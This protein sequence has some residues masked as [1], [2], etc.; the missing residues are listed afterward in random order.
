MYVEFATVMEIQLNLIIQL[1][2]KVKF[3]NYKIIAHAFTGLLNNTRNMLGTCGILWYSQLFFPIDNYEDRVL[4]F[5]QL[6]NACQ[7]LFVR[8][9]WF[10][11]Y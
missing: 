10:M 5:I 11:R 8:F 6:L 2:L 4:Q 9:L 7:P 1:K 3:L